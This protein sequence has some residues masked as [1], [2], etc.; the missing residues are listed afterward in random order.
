MKALLIPMA[1]AAGCAFVSWNT[2]VYADDVKAEC[3]VH[4]RGEKK[5]GQSGPCLYSQRQGFIDIRLNNGKEYSLSPKEGK[6]GVYNDQ[7]GR[8]VERTES[9]SAEHKYQWEH[10]NIRVKFN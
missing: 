2:P 9:G 3:V 4:E 7:E 10:R 1:I 6:P 8:R 5:K